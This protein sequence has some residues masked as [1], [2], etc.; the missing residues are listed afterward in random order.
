MVEPTKTVGDGTS[1]PIGRTTWI[2]FSTHD[3]TYQ[4]V[5]LQ[6][7]RPV[8][9][10]KHT[11]YRHIM[12][13]INEIVGSV[14]KQRLQEIQ[15]RKFKCAAPVE[16]LHPPASFCDGSAEPFFRNIKI[17]GHAVMPYIAMLMY[18]GSF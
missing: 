7:V 1:I 2:V 5:W 15:M 4:I 9:R 17:V 3:Q 11:C 16:Y 10:T 8:L 18:I 14:C 6:L 13:P 12:L